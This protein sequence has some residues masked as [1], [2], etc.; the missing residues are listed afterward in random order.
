MRISELSR[1][2]DI[3]VATI[4]F[5]LREG[6]LHEGEHT[7]ATQAR[8]NE[9]H[10]A[11]LR[12]IRAL[13]GP[14]GLSLA[15]T[16]DVLEAIDDPPESVHDLLGVAAA[17]VTPATR[18]GVEHEEVHALLREWGWRVD[19]KDCPSHAALAEAL[20]GLAA[21]GFTLP[22]AALTTYRDH[23]AALGRFEIDT[24]PTDSAMSAVR[25]VVLG[26]VLVEPLLL[27]LRRL[28]Q[29]EFSARR[30]GLREEPEP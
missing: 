13:T 17:V 14:G 23:M 19:S 11:R 30:F 7:A 8:Y 29:Q 27:A 20:N 6:L 25:H 26:T 5:Y 2:S 28:A 10:L 21:A 1:A 4:K 24:V 12:V 22:E 18:E 16:R 9:S 3:S 15:A